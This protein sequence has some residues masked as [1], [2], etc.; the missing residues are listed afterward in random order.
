MAAV[1]SVSPPN[2][3]CGTVPRESYY[4]DGNYAGYMVPNGVHG[5]L[6]Y[7]WTSTTYIQPSVPKI[8]PIRIPTMKLLR[9]PTFGQV[10]QPLSPRT[11]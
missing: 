9:R 8:A 5:G 4:Y 1:V 2:P 7:D 3:V 11:T 6:S 10:Y